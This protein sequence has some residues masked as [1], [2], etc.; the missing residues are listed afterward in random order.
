MTEIGGNAFNSCTSLESIALPASLTKVK[1]AAFANCSAL[2]TVELGS[3]LKS[4]ERSAFVNCTALESIA[5]PASMTEI[6]GGAFYNCSSL[7]GIAIP[8]SVTSIG[9]G[10]FG[11]CANLESVEF[12]GARNPIDGA[13]FKNCTK[14]HDFYYGGTEAEW[15]G[16]AQPGWNDN[17]ADTQVV[18][19]RYPGTVSAKPAQGG[20]ASAAIELT[21]EKGGS[22]PVSRTAAAEARANAG[23]GFVSWTEGGAVAS[24]SAR[25]EFS[26]DGARSLTANFAVK[27]AK[28]KIRT[29]AQRA[30]SAVRASWGAVAGAKG[31]QL[32]WRA[33]GGKWKAA[34]VKGT[35]RT[36]KG[37]KAGKTYQFRVRA[38][39][40]STKGPW[41]G[42]SSRYFQRLKAVAAKPGKETGSI[43]VRWKADPKADAGYMVVVR[44][45]KSGA[46]I[47]RKAVAAGKT[48]ATVKGLKSGKRVWVQ[49]RS[50]RSAG[51]RVATGVLRSCPKYVK[52]K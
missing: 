13:W 44:A 37:L 22:D 20:T 15:A 17:A 27:L 4:I 5:F 43:S 36:V 41:S 50:L 48:K 1:D 52:V 38:V 33:K 23:Y 35:S 32:Q 31:Y 42:V 19:C 24:T 34:A 25:Y 3:G 30:K 7:K 9:S 45:K 40:G 11:N 26:A 6:G 47:A 49:V 12:K 18:H 16:A 46:A 51:G 28:P 10:A 14:L 39:A 29:K 2:A 21:Y 8:A